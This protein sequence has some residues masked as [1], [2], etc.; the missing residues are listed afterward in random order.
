MSQV[1]QAFISYVQEDEE[2]LRRLQ[3]HL[4][5][6]RKAGL[7]QTWHTQLIQAGNQIAIDVDR[8]LRAADLVIVLLSADFIA[9]D[10]YEK[11]LLVGLQRYELGQA[12][13][14]PIVVRPCHYECTCL[15]VLQMLPRDMKAVASSPNQEDTWRAISIE[16]LSIAESLAGRV[17]SA[18]HSLTKSSAGS[19]API[20]SRSE[21]AVDM[22]AHVWPF[23]EPELQDALSLAYNDA[24]RA[25]S[26]RIKTQRLFAALRRIR[27]ATAI[28]LMDRLPEGALPA[29]TAGELD[30]TRHLFDEDLK[31]STC[32]SDSLQFMR[33]N[34]PTRP[35]VTSA[36]MLVD[37]A[38]YDTG[39]S[40]ATLRRHG[41]GPDE[42]DSLI[43]D[44]GLS[45]I[46]RRADRGGERSTTSAT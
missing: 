9:S 20:H 36:D 38:R 3:V 40:V 13:L 28:A 42:I 37:I 31:F 27:P 4:A 30:T 29:P 17:S 14:V 39:S 44:E 10:C 22:L 34:I 18:S 16:I 5:P 11:E 1:T 7:I 33:E 23:L 41:I 19:F 12:Q 45:V 46:D 35:H 15:R 8:H 24:R 21:T 32:V 2:Y 26:A 43:A 25:G 6:V